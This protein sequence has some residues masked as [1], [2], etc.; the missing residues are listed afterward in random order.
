MRDEQIVEHL[1][2]EKRNGKSLPLRAWLCLQDMTL[3]HKKSL[4]D[5]RDLALLLT[6]PTGKN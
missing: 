1:I 6:A 5:L 2:A 3:E 4:Y